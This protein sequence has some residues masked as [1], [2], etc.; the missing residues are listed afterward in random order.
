MCHVTSRPVSSVSLAVWLGRPGDRSRLPLLRLPDAPGLTCRF[1]QRSRPV[2]P[3]PRSSLWASQTAP[4]LGRV[5]VSGVTTCV[6]VKS[7]FPDASRRGAGSVRPAR[8]K[9]RAK[10]GENRDVGRKGVGEKHEMFAR[11]APLRLQRPRG[12]TQERHRAPGPEGRP[13]DASSGRL[14]LAGAPRLRW[15]REPGRIAWLLGTSGTSISAP[16][17]FEDGPMNFPSPGTPVIMSHDVGKRRLYRCTDSVTCPL[18]R[19]DERKERGFEAPPE[20]SRRL[21][22]SLTARKAPRA[23]C[24]HRKEPPAALAPPRAS[25][26]HPPGQIAQ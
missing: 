8:T 21:E 6:S 26:V 16:S 20:T 3:R 12:P 7:C 15:S 24:S 2:E 18:R 13:P 19:A 17:F 14:A 1:A 4:A 5:A 23:S 11:S 22:A 25:P 9:T 10:T